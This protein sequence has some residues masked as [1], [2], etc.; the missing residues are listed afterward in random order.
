M[1]AA[2][3]IITNNDRM[4]KSAQIVL[5]SR[6]VLDLPDIKLGQKFKFNYKDNESQCK[7]MNVKI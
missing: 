7:L 5:D 3:N 1:K 2:E 6:D 4:V